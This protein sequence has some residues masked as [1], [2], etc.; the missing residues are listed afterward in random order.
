M[1]LIRYEDLLATP[2]SVVN[3]VFQFLE[4]PS[5]KNVHKYLQT[6]LKIRDAGQSELSVDAKMAAVPF[7]RH[8]IQPN[9]AFTWRHKMTFSQ[10]LSVQNQCAMPMSSLGYVAVDT[11]RDMTNVSV[12]VVNKA[13]AEI[14]HLP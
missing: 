11:P 9:P 7:D 8:Q 14:W 5:N 2:H 6:T 1:L 3:T 10:V 13:Y 12:N 4:L